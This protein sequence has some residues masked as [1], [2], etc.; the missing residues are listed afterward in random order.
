[1]QSADRH[2]CVEPWIHLFRLD[3][4]CNE[5]TRD[6]QASRSRVAETESPRIGEESD[7]Q[8][9]RNI[10]RDLQPENDSEIVDQ[11]AGCARGR[12][13]NHQGAWRFIARQMMIYYQLRNLERAYS[14]GENAEALH[15]RYVENDQ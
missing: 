1:M 2:G 10:R 11:L 7:V 4:R 8:R 15:I 6:A 3:T 14:F 13:G 9:P 12:I 5:L